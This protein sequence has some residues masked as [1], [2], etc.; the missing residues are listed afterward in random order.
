MLYLGVSFTCRDLKKALSQNDPV[1]VCRYSNAFSLSQ[2]A[3]LWRA[4]GE[5][6]LCACVKKKERNS[7]QNKQRSGR[8]Y[9][10]FLV[11]IWRTNTQMLYFKGV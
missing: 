6:L 4:I 10:I 2:K 1:Y 9:H 5:I 7:L 8:Q 11:N 3:D